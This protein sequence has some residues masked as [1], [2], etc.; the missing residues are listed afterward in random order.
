MNVSKGRAP[1]NPHGGSALPSLYVSPWKL[2]A[3]DARAVLASLG[4]RARELWRR[5][6]SAELPLPMVWPRALASLFWPLVLVGVLLLVGA[7]VSRWHGR[8]AGSVAVVPLPVP[9]QPL[10]E[11]SAGSELAVVPSGGESLALASSA[12][13]PLDESQA[14]AEAL[15][16]N[17][18]PELALDPLMELLAP[19]DGPPLLVAAR[20]QPERSRLV[21]ELNAAFLA[22][23]PP[24]RQLQADRWREQAAVLGFEELDLRDGR[25]RMLGRQ[26]RVGTGMILLSY[27]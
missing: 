5:N 15:E 12:V 20:P 16:A 13:P 6:G 21:L 11:A 26:A 17:P 1:E 24:A 4:L 14:E 23:P 9:S 7:G 22:L 8:A 3:E 27:G 25:G 19:G 18:L 2:L 10:V